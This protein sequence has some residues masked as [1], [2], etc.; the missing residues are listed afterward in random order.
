M[1]VP[2]NRKLGLIFGAGFF[3]AL[4]EPLIL[5][6]MGD[7]IGGA[8]W[9]MANRSLDWTFSLR[10]WR[11]EV[12]A[13]F[14]FAVP[15]CFV[16]SN[17]SSNWEKVIATL[18]IGVIFGLFLIFSLLNMAYL[19]D[20]FILL[21]TTFGM[22]M[23]CAAF[24]AGG[25]V[26]NPFKQETERFS[27]GVH[28][29]LVIAA[30][31][32]ISPG[33]TA[34]AGLLP[35]PPELEMEEGLYE[36][37]TTIHQYPMPVEVSSIQ[38]DYEEDV[39]FSVYLT[40]PNENESEI[41]LAIIL[42]GFANPFFDTYADWVEELASR[43]MAVAFIQYPSDVMPPGY[44]TYELHEEEGMSN[45]P[46]HIPRAIAIDAALEFMTTILPDNVNHDHLLI[47]GHSL[48][49]G[50]AL[51]ALDWS[52]DRGWGNE[53]LFVDLEAP[54]ARP[55]QDHLQIDT[56]GLPD[57]FLAHVVISEDD[58][59][60]DDCFGVYHQ[61]LLGENALFIE[62]PSD[63]HGFPRL[64]ASHYLQASETHDSLAD[65]SFYRRVAA[66]ADWLVARTNGDIITE[67]ETLVELKDSQEL[68]NMGQWSDGEDVEKLRVW[69]NA[70]NSD[71]FEHCKTWTGP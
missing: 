67:N 8:L 33:L 66:Q 23:L 16:R 65:W 48:G 26:S 34:M 59:S 14:L 41:P 52:L 20:A 58:M 5:L 46:F 40:I 13:F 7:D 70:L 71:R 47:G 60:V 53:S 35:T 51:L 22:I 61:S 15:I 3:L 21:P 56:T 68:R 62:V 50:Y 18:V 25:T 17:K 42:H 63:R 55:V 28:L 64:V 19:K 11:V 10:A 43:G 9:P 57:D 44:D 39:T 45:H 6:A 29:L 30:I 12:F 24:I 49:A 54:Y 4:L 1:D 37:E 36:F 27:R 32:L 31:W 69:D 38:G 2:S